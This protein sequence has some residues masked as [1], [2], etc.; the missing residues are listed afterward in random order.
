LLLNQEGVSWC[1]EQNGAVART[2]AVVV[3]VVPTRCGVWQRRSVIMLVTNDIFLGIDIFLL[4][5][6]LKVATFCLKLR[7]FA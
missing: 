7:H 5:V 1:L 2:A 6:L 4:K 3:E